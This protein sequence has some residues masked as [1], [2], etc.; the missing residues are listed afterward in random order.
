M[1]CMLFSILDVRST[2]VE[3][4]DTAPALEEFIIIKE[5]LQCIVMREEWGTTYTWE[6]KKSFQSKNASL[7]FTAPNHRLDRDWSPGTHCLHVDCCNQG[8][9]SL[10]PHPWLVPIYKDL[11]L[12]K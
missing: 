10:Y 7:W 2:I 8:H 11:G 12:D 1:N 4:M 9:A 6:S 5:Q 3:K